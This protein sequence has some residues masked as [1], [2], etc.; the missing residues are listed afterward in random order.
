MKGKT[1]F[2]DRR[3]LLLLTAF[4]LSLL[5]VGC[6]PSISKGLKNQVDK[7][8]H[9]KEV[10]KNPDAF[11]GKVVMWGGVIL[12]AKNQKG[13]TL[14]EVLQKPLDWDDRPQDGD[15][16][17]GRFLGLYEGFLDTA[18]YAKGREVTV[19]GEIQGK[20]VLPM[21]EI[22]YTYPFLAVKEVHLWP[23]RVKERIVPAPYWPYPWWWGDPYYRR[24]PRR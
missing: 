13:G 6:G 21:D 20:K 9:F 18:L 23:E 16:S 1:S 3:F 8:I 17:H 2:V 11:K 10:L 24:P 12:E 5:S 15:E 7:D 19:A 4:C 22:D 14:L